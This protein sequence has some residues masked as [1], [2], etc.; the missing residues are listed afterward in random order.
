M[1]ILTSGQGSYGNSN[2]GETAFSLI[3]KTSIKIK[4][5][6]LIYVNYD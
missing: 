2:H 6:C 5:I 4:Q 1:L 3:K